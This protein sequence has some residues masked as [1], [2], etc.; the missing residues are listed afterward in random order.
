ML[1]GSASDRMLLEAKKASLSCRTRLVHASHNS[2]DVSPTKKKYSACEVMLKHNEELDWM[3][4][5]DL[6]LRSATPLIARR[7]HKTCRMP[8]CDDAVEVDD[9]NDVLIGARATA[10]FSN[11]DYLMWIMNIANV[12]SQPQNFQLLMI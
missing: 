11:I 9:G 12:S 2:P 4:R 10:E 8:L 5:H 6:G 3:I 1:M 7:F